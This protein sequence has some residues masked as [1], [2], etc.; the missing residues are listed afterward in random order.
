[1]NRPF[2]RGAGPDEI[3]ST[4]REDFLKAAREYKPDLTLLSAGFDSHVNDPLGGFNLDDDSFRE[5]TK[6]MV[7]I[8]DISGKGRL[9]SVLEGGYSLSSLASAVYAH[10]DEL[11]QA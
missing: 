9:I 5:L 11:R 6:I 8:A 7:E 10:V 1:M 4:F 2:W 3:V